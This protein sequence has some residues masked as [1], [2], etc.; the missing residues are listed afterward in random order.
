M[1]GVGGGRG[2]P[3]AGCPAAGVRDSMGPEGLDGRRS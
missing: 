3:Q 1:L 2:T